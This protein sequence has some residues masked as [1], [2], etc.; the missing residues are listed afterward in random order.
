MIGVDAS[1]L[2]TVSTRPQLAHQRKSRVRWFGI[3]AVVAASVVIAVAMSRG[4]GRT[5]LVLPRRLPDDWALLRAERQPFTEQLA[6]GQ[7]VFV[8]GDANGSGFARTLTVYRYEA[9]VEATPSLSAVDDASLETNGSYATMTFSAASCGPIYLSTTGVTNGDTRDAA[10]K[11][12][13]DQTGLHVI[14][15]AG[16][17]QRCVSDYRDERIALFVV[18]NGSGATAVFHVFDNSCPLGMYTGHPT[19]IAGRDVLFDD[20]FD[21]YRLD[22]FFRIGDSMIWGQHLGSDTKSARADLESLIKEMR[23]VTVD[24]FDHAV[25]R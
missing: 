23:N 11:V 3:L 16:M 13:C 8:A 14:A 1:P 22:C 15:P 10:R 4:D 18:G 24:Q 6:Q 9:S 19:V 7:Y 20:D 25:A 21:G 5:G 12:F 2:A 17:K